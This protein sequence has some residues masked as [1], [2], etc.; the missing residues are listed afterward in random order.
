MATPPQATGDRRQARRVVRHYSRLAP[1]YDRSWDRYSQGSLGKLVERL[2][3]RGSERVLDIACGTGRL[4]ALLRERHPGIDITGVDLSPDMLA[5]ARKRL[6]EDARTR[7]LH[8]TLETLELPS[9]SFDLVTCNNAFHLFPEQQG[10]LR[11]MAEL[12]R[13][14]GLVALIDWC[15][16]YPQLALL[17][18]LANIGRGQRRRILTRAELGGMLRAAGLDMTHEER[19]RA[20]PFW[21]MMCM[22]ARRPDEALP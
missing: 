10:S 18:L 21:G 20:T 19:F 8:G 9:A 12:A 6:P 4:E 1:D 16:E 13:P 2:E 3:L 5:V 11:R 7:W 22:M 17:Q 14:G 15:R